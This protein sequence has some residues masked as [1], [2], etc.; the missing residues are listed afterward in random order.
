MW[1]RPCVA[2]VGLIYLVQGLFLVWMPVGVCHQCVLIVISLIG[3]VQVRWLVLG[4]GV[5][6]SGGGS[7]APPEHVMGMEVA[8]DHSWSPGG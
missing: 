5:L 4:P 8:C 3:D 6:G 1:G 2:C 7:G